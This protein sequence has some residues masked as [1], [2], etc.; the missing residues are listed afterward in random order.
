MTIT[1]YEHA[2]LSIE[3]EG[4]KLVIDPGQFSPSYTA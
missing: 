4:K 1:K 2:C 3:E